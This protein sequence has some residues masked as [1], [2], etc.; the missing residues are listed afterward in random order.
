MLAPAFR[1][2]GRGKGGLARVMKADAGAPRR[3]R[4]DQ[5]S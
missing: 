4:K 3:N 2:D 5:T 1:G